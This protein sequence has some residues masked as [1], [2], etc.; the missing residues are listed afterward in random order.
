M[1]VSSATA[2]GS[3]HINPG[4]PGKMNNQDAVAV[5]TVPKKEIIIAVLCDGCG[6]EPASE[7][8]AN[9][10]AHLIAREIKNSLLAANDPSIRT[11]DWGRFS[12]AFSLLLKD[13]IALFVKDK[14]VAAFEEE[15]Q[16]HFLFTALILIVVKNQA[17]IVSFGDGVVMIDDEVIKLE[18]PIKNTP[19]YCSYTL[20]TATG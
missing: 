19:P 6:S 15:A 1:H 13:A 2:P 14:G 16:R 5:V 12:N 9:I 3:A 8:G 18:P 11:I 10:G 17:I 4:R 20:F 7:V